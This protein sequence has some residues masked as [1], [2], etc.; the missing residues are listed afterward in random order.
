MITLK[1]ALMRVM[2]AATSEKERAYQDFLQARTNLAFAELALNTAES[3]VTFAQQRVDE[4]HV[5]LENSE[6]PSN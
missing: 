6:T 5:L 2:V 4:L 1:E 3:G